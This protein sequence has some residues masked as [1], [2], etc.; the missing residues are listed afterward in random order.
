MDKYEYKTDIEDHSD[1]SLYKEI[2]QYLKEEHSG[3]KHNSAKLDLLFEE[4]KN[5]DDD[6][7]DQA[8]KD[9]LAEFHKRVAMQYQGEDTLPDY[10]EDHGSV[11]ILEHRRIIDSLE[12]PV[13]D[14]FLCSVKGNSMQNINID[15]GDTLVVSISERVENG[16]VIIAD[17]GGAYFVKRYKLIDD[18]IWLVS[19]N[20]SI[21]DVLV[22]KDMNFHI[23]GK[24]IGVFKRF[25]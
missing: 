3:L 10:S 12:Y 18:D 9:A 20:V 15:N 13:D 21:N 16:D 22:K 24:V 7:Y 19:E 11:D 14:I 25:I 23:A 2:K 17:I 8:E 4:S 6:I 5:R 1:F